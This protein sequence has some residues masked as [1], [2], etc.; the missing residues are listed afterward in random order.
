MRLSEP[1]E[2][3]PCLR[4]LPD[5]KSSMLS[6]NLSLIC[7]TS[8]DFQRSSPTFESLINMSKSSETPLNKESK[9]WNSNQVEVEEE[10]EEEISLLKRLKSPTLKQRLEESVFEVTAPS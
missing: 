4:P 10:E 7:Q 6:K 2:L 3:E 8:R 5:S 9:G 1:I